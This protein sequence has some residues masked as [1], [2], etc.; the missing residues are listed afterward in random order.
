MRPIERFR[1]ELGLSQT[2]QP[3]LMELAEL[4]DC[5]FS[6]Y[7]LLSM[8]THYLRKNPNIELTI[9]LA[10]ILTKLT[11]TMPATHLWQLL[12]L[13]LWKHDA[14]SAEQKQLCRYYE[15]FSQWITSYE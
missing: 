2:T 14:I 9:D 7:M 5:P 4:A 12:H 11:R 15:V 6:N 10:G 1:V 8:L 13:C 3:T